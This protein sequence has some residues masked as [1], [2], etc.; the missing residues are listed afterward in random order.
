MSA[1][2][3]ATGEILPHS[4]L[5]RLEDP[6]VRIIPALAAPRLEDLAEGF[7]AACHRFT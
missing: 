6:G 5:E 1:G 4:V 7:Q 2:I 3:V